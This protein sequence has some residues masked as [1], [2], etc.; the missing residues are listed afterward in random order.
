MHITPAVLIALLASSVRAQGQI[1]IDSTLGA[2]PSVVATAQGETHVVPDRAVILIGVETQG[3]TAA[4]ASAENARRQRL[5]IDTIRAMGIGAD[6][7]T[8]LDYGVYPQQSA[9]DKTGAP[10]RITAYRVT[11][12]VRVD[13]HNLDRLGPLIDATLAKGANTIN[14]LS[15]YSSTEDEARRDALGAAVRRARADAEAMARAAGGRLGHLLELSS[16]GYVGPSPL[17]L[18]APMAMRSAV[19]TPVSPGEQTIS[20]SVTARWAFRESQN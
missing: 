16:G 13:V 7:I 17:M 5:V 8:T 14:S 1:H 4:K 3:P 2:Q 9:P 6:Q 10:P 18:A 12:T 19:A 20:A 11:N 15:F